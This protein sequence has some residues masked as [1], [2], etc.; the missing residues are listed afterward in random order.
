MAALS[1]ADLGESERKQLLRVARQSIAHGLAHGRPRPVAPDE[2][3]GVLA[4]D[5]ASFVT[6]H[7]AGALR[8]CVGSLEARQPLAIDV[9]KAAFSA[10][11]RD[12]RFPP[13]GTPEFPEVEIEISVLSPMTRI[14]ARDRDEL[15]QALRPQVDGLLLEEAR[16]RATFLPKVWEQLG[17]PRQFLAALMRK[18]GLGEDYWSPTLRLFRYQTLCFD[19]RTLKDNVRHA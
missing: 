3:N 7:R 8:G 17:D 5:G 12:S 10:A 16:Q 13:L 15:L 11:F 2:V 6:L 9:A 4:S 14:N 18:A 1:F 19:E